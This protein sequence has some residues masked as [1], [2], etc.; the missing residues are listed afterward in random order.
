MLESYVQET[1]TRYQNNP[2]VFC[3]D[4]YNEPGG[5]GQGRRS[6]GLL[7][8]AFQWVRA[9]K[10]SQPLTSGIHAIRSV[11][12]IAAQHS[13]I[14]TFHHYGKLEELDALVTELEGSGRPLICT[15]YLARNMGSL[16]T[17]HLP[18]FQKSRSAPCTGAL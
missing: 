6:A 2:T 8:A 16:F 10:P 13:D 4:L 15:E 9:A 18:Y 14:I 1:I 3:W 17:T 11:A 5:S 12:A 7:E